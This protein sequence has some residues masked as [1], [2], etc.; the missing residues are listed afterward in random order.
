[1]NEQFIVVYLMH[2]FEMFFYI[3]AKCLTLYHG[4]VM[5]GIGKCRY[6]SWEKHN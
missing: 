6:L 5:T 1:M 3:I 2:D 4:K